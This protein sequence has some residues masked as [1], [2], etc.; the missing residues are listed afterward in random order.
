VSWVGEIQF[1][2]FN[3]R[4]KSIV[5][6]LLRSGILPFILIMTLTASEKQ[7]LYNRHNLNKKSIENAIDL[8]KQDLRYCFKEEISQ[9]NYTIKQPFTN[10]NRIRLLENIRSYNQILLGLLVSWSEESIICSVRDNFIRIDINIA[11]DNAKEKFNILKGKFE[12]DSKNIFGDELIWDELP[13][14]KQSIIYYKKFID[15]KN[16]NLWNDQH[17]WFRSN[18]E[19]FDE[20]FRPKIK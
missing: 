11:G 3:S 4:P 19:K 5:M 6:N 20:Y 18:L 17:E 2:G 1:T 9:E 15:V 13:N 12:S 16:R 14:A 10:K 7:R 8:I